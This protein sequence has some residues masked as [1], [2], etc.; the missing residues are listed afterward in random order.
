MTSR[1]VRECRRNRSIRWKV[2]VVVVDH[3]VKIRSLDE[4]RRWM[5]RANFV[6]NEKKPKFNKIEESRCRL[7]GLKATGLKNDA[8]RA[9]SCNVVLVQV[10]VGLDDQFRQ[11]L[12]R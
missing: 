1:E 12:V 10:S 6:T 11:E 2:V 8:K 3:D 7:Q 9:V 4:R 5:N